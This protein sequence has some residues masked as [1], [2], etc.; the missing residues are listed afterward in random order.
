MNF[1]HNFHTSMLKTTLRQFLPGDNGQGWLDSLCLYQEGDIIRV[2]FP[3]AYFGAWFSRHKRS[4]FEEALNRHFKGG[5]PRICYQ[6]TSVS[7]ETFPMSF[8]L[9]ESSATNL[10][11][12]ER[13]DNIPDRAA[14]QQDYFASFLSNAK[15]AFPLAAAKEVA[16]HAPGTIYNPFLLCGRSGT[17]KSHLLQ[18][19]E[20]AFSGKTLPG[21]VIRQKALTFCRDNAVSLGRPEVFWQ[22]CAVLLLDDLQELIEHH[23]WQQQIA[24]LMDAC[25][26]E[27]ERMHQMIFAYAAPSQT[28]KTFD[29]RLYSR[30]EGGLVLELLEPDLDVR[31]R[32][33]QILCRER[34]LHLGRDQLMYLAQRCT[35]FRLLQGLILKLEAFVNIRGRNLSPS[36]LENIVRT[37]GVARLPACR[38]ILTGVAASFN[39][40][41]EDIL[42][43]KRRPDLVLARQMAMYVCRQRLGL[44]YPELGRAFGGRDHSTVIY[45]IKKIKQLMKTDKTVYHKVTELENMTF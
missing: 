27:A 39:L 41:P 43:S 30:L 3:H 11:H 28:L 44:S 17:G 15:N 21:R 8:P 29:E 7:T 33:L 13:S 19:L 34:Q 32:Y 26:R 31:L 37:G 16:S 5:M 45:A 23:L 14:E 6:S 1:I 10:L 42:G 9:T 12:L 25:P 38:D 20:K 18:V 35:Q 40:R 2:T 24:A 36:D 22:D 4:L